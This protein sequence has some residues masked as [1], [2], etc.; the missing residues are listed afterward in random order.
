MKIYQ[1]MIGGIPHTMQFPE[2]E[3]PDG[4]VEVKVGPAPVT[5]QRKPR[6]KSA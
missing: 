4:A 6:N 2:G 3:Q 5:K 1:V